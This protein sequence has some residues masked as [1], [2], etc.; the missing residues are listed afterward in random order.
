MREAKTGRA[1]SLTQTEE[2]Q[3][4]ADRYS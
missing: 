3:V 1:L 2:E 4:K